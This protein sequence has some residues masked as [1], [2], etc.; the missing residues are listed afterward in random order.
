MPVLCEARESGV[1]ARRLLKLGTGQ[2]SGQLHTL[3]AL[4]LEKEPEW[5][6]SRSERSGES[7]KLCR[8][9]GSSRDCLSGSLVS[10][11][12]ET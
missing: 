3:N 1:T 9:W 10:L 6:H 11:Y 5:A 12:R 4:H 2:V 8:H 7:L